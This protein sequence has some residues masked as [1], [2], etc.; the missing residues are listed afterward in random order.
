MLHKWQSPFQDIFEIKRSVS[1]VSERRMF[2]EIEKRPFPVI[3]E[4]SIDGTRNINKDNEW[5]K[6]VSEPRRRIEL[7]FFLCW[8]GDGVMSVGFSRFVHMWQQFT[9]CTTGCVHTVTCHAHSVLCCIVCCAFRTFSCVYACAHTRMGQ[10]FWKLHCTCVFFHLVFFFF[11]FMIHQSSL[12]FPHSHFETNP[13]YDFVDSDIY[14]ILSWFPVLFPHLYHE[15]WV[16]DQIRK[17]QKGRTFFVTLKRHHQT[18]VVRHKGK[19]ASMLHDIL[20]C[21]VDQHFFALIIVPSVGIQGHGI[22]VVLFPQSGTLFQYTFVVHVLM[23]RS[24]IHDI[25]KLGR[26][27]WA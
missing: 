12:L 10:V 19:L 23:Q 17:T 1:S 4:K 15:V 22:A 18:V 2:R 6:E 7:F 14:M 8:D 25:M 13:G 16:F 9:A 5:W 20:L 27:L 11:F 21:D 3:D 24:V 26:R